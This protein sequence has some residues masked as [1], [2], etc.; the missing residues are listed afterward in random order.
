MVA[1]NNMSVRIALAVINV[2]LYG[3]I[4]L[5]SVWGIQIGLLMPS[6]RRA[7]KSLNLCAPSVGLAQLDQI[8]SLMT[9]LYPS[10]PLWYNPYV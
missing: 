1:V 4:L 7:A 5:H 6:V 9:L 2:I 10:L 3:F 8:V